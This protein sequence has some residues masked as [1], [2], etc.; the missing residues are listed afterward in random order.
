[1]RWTSWPLCMRRSET[2]EKKKKK[3]R[4]LTTVCGLR[5][6]MLSTYSTCTYWTNKHYEFLHYA[7]KDTRWETA[8]YLKHPE[9]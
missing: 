5:N 7:L 2:D 3:L 6:F 8:R 4:T 1:M 9:I